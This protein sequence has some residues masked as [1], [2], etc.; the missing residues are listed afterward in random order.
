MKDVLEGRRDTRQRRGR[1]DGGTVGRLGRKDG[2]TTRTVGREKSLRADIRRFLRI[3]LML[4]ICGFVCGNQRRS[5]FK[6]LMLQWK[7]KVKAMTNERICESA[8]V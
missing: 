7:E 3:I 6:A 1:L 4:Y 5:A 8:D 2:W